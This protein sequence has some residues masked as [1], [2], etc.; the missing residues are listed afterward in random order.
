MFEIPCQNILGEN[1]LWQQ[2]EQ[3]VYWTDI[4]GKSLYKCAMTSEVIDILSADAIDAHITKAKEDYFQQ[5][6]QVF[7]LPFRLGSFAF[8][9]DHH[10]LLA[11][12]ENGVA[13]YNYTSGSIE[14]QGD[15]RL[16]FEHLRYNDGK[17]DSKGRFWLGSMV[18]NTNAKKLSA[19]EQ[20]ALYSFWFENGQ[21]RNKKALSGI[22]ISNSLCFTEDAKVM[23]HSDS[24]SH[25][26]YQYHLSESGDIELR[27]VFAKF[28]KNT[29]P[30][31][32]CTDIH[33]N[34]WVALWGAACVA[35]FDS[36]GNE[37]LRHPLAVTQG[38]CVSIGGPNMDWLFVTSASHFLSDEKRALQGRAGNLFV[39]EIS[40][41]LGKT[42]EHIS[43]L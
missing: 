35:C 16:P 1:V 12:F 40:E 37:L 7:D 19:E 23:Y 36:K 3:A 11:G 21:L 10:T 41:A 4:E 20:G 24:S 33:G 14:W 22:T 28:D 27:K 25:K 34:V 31:G 29:F 5:V 2:Q 15:Y 38:T 18:E 43:I 42:E 32:A 39:Y 13:L 30:D 26:I 6:L 17:C 9:D 8:T